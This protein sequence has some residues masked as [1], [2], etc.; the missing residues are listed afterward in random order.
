MYY[1]IDT[2]Y[3]SKT[4]AEVHNRRK[5]ILPIRSGEKKSCT[6][7]C[8]AESQGMLCLPSGVEDIED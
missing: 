8:D 2:K 7:S 4:M 5:K 1:D 3:N 6:T